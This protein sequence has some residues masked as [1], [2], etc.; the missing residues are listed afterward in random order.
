MTRDQVAKLL[1]LRDASPGF[2]AETR[3]RLRYLLG[4]PEST[5]LSDRQAEVLDAVSFGGRHQLV[6]AP[7]PAD[8]EPP[9]ARDW[10]R[11]PTALHRRGRFINRG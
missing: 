8:P 9:A 7:L 6:H 2:D 5:M 10:Q 4:M 1:A 11:P 3:W